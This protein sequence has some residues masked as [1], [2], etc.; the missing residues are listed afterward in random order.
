M[1]MFFLIARNLAF[2]IKWLYSLFMIISYFQIK[3]LVARSKEEEI[4][5]ALIL[6]KK[7]KPLWRYIVLFP[8]AF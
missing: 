3:N 1:D 2:L 4:T 7:N 6:I 5:C 8:G